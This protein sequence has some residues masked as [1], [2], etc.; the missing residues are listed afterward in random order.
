MSNYHQPPPALVAAAAAARV[1]PRRLPLPWHKAELFA[2]PRLWLRLWQ[3]FVSWL[4][5]APAQPQA[6][7]EGDGYADA[8]TFAVPTSADMAQLLKDQLRAMLEGGAQA[9]SEAAQVIAAVV[10]RAR[11]AGITE[12][13]LPGV[14]NVAR[15]VYA[16]HIA[17]REIEA[18]EERRAQEAHGHEL[19]ANIAKQDT[20][21]GPQQSSE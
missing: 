12:H 16:A 17:K 4:C 5:Y 14:A 13:G 1:A 2:Q 11:A 6:F 21:A 3:A 19:E 8:P 10:D 20:A 15:D 18:L 9:G 7:G